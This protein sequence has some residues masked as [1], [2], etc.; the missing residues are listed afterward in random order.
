MPN[1]LRV[2]PRQPVPATAIIM[3]NMMTVIGKPVLTLLLNTTQNIIQMEKSANLT[4]TEIWSVQLMK[5]IRLI[6]PKSFL[7]IK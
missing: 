3:R 6:L 1:L 7:E 2:F 4:M 5:K